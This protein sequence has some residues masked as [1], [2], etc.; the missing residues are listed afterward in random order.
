MQVVAVRFLVK[1]P[2][3]SVDIEETPAM[4][5]FTFSAGHQ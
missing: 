3:I 1:F 2:G 5:W 4:G